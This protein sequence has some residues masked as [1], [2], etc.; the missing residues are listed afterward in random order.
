MAGFA[1]HLAKPVE[2]DVLVDT[3]ERLVPRAAAR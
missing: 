2:P 1:A 3:L